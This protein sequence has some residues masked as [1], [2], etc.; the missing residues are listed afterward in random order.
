MT[1]ATSVTSTI[2]TWDM[3]E[4]IERPPNC[5]IALNQPRVQTVNCAIPIFRNVH[6]AKGSCSVWSI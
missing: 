6:S 1:L 2:G 4:K 5:A 3:N